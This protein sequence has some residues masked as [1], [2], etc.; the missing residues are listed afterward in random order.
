MAEK[1]GP[2]KGRI[3]VQANRYEGLVVW[4]TSS[5]SRPARRSSPGPTQVALDKAPTERRWR[6]SAA[7]RARRSP[8]PNLTTSNEDTAR[9]GFEAGNSTF[10]IN[11]PF[12]YPSAKANAPEDLQ[13]DGRGEVSRASTRASRASRRSAA[14][15]SASRRT[16]STRTLAFAATE[17]LVKPE[18]QLEVAKLGGLPPVRA[19]PLRPA[20]DREG[21]SRLRRPDPRRR[22]SDAAPR[23]SESPAYQDLSL[24]IQ[25][26]RAPDDEDRPEEPRGRPTTSCATT[27]RRPSSARACCEHAVPVGSRRAR[28]TGRPDRPTR[29]APSA[30]SRSCC[31]RRPSSRCCS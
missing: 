27:S 8:P 18:N 3:Q 9:L 10:M 25:R 4:S 16:P 22:S 30:S 19:G 14:S 12:V 15:T 5:S 11:Y 7:C 13:A 17:C 26:A 6:S 1:I 29:R 28:R 21:L 20:R 24:A 23:P 2:A 31:A